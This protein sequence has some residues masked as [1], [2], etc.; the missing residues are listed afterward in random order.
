MKKSKK[1]LKGAIFRRIAT[2][3][4]DKFYVPE[5]IYSLNGRA[6]AKFAL[7]FKLYIN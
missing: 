6:N 2:Q 5:S 1:C 3:A 4:A 7:P